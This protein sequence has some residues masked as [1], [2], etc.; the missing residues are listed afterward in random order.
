[1]LLDGV[2]AGAIEVVGAGPDRLRGAGDRRFPANLEGL[3][4]RRVVAGPEPADAPDLLADLR[5]RVLAG[6]ADSPRAWID[7]AATF[8]PARTAAELVA[9]GVATPLERRC[10]FCLSVD[11][12]AEAEARARLRAGAS[13]ALAAAAYARGLALAG[14]LPPATHTLPPAARAIIAALR[15]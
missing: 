7:R 13:V 3:E 8:A 2:L 1:L 10:R 15:S 4:R 12:R 5:A 11:A 14:P 9:A 6:P